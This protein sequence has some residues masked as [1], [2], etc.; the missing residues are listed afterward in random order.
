MKAALPLIVL[1]LGTCVIGTCQQQAQRGP[2]T[3]EE[4]ER[5]I[6]IA[7]KMEAAPLD[8]SLRK[9]REWAL[10]WLVQIPDITAEVCTAPLGDFMKKK[11]KYSPEIITQLTFSSGA[12]VIEH[13]GQSKDLPAQRLAAVEGALKAYKSILQAKPDAKSKSLDELLDKQHD[14][15]LADHVK[16]T[17]S[18]GCNN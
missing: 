9:E 17:S 5:F 1:I 8:P 13:P 16:D 11:Y 6:A 18:K 3:Q 15:K 7:H 14:G 2:S 12:F 4:R 10:L